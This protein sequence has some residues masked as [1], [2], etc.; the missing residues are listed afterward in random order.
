MVTNVMVVTMSSS[1]WNIASA[2]AELSQVIRQARRRP[3]VIERR[4]QPVAVV[5]SMADYQRV[6]ASERSADRWQSVLSLSAELR[7]DGGA[8]LRIPRRQPRRSPFGRS[9]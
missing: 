9:R 7:A 3:Q 2:K 8:T 4:G 6:T 1:R 5:F